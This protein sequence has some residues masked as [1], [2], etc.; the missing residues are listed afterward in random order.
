M[1]HKRKNTCELLLEE[2]RKHFREAIRQEKGRLRAFDFQKYTMTSSFQESGQAAS[3][4]PEHVPGECLAAADVTDVP[5]LKRFRLQHK[6]MPIELRTAILHLAGGVTLN[7]RV[8]QDIAKGLGMHLQN[9]VQYPGPVQLRPP[10]C[11]ILRN[12]I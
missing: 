10:P 4:A 7:R 8:L 1:S 6:D 3:G 9:A 11:K 5:T 2:V 12:C